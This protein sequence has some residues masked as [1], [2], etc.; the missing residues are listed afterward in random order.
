[1]HSPLNGPHPH[2]TPD[3]DHPLGVGPLAVVG[4][5]GHVGLPL[6]LAFA[7]KGY[8][9]DLLDVSPERIAQVNAGKMP[10]NEEGA[11]ALLA[12]VVRAAESRRRPTRPSSKTPPPSSS[13]SARPSMNT[14]TRRSASSTA[15]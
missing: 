2:P 11:D 8:A 12:E 7:R 5:C 4:G 10:F 9:V 13:P 15:R 3:A 6:G 14:L 1:M